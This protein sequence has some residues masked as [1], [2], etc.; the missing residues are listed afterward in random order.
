MIARCA[1]TAQSARWQQPNAWRAAW[2]AVNSFGAFLLT[3]CAIYLTLGVS[4]WLTISLA[5]LAGL[6]LV[7]VFI[8]FHDC[9]HGSFFE[10]RLANDALGVVTGF[11]A[12]VPYHHWR[13]EHAIHHGSA[14]DLERRGTGDVWT[15]TVSEYLSSPRARRWAYRIV[16]SP[17]IL[18]SVGPLALLLLWQRM[19]RAS[20]TRRERHSVWWT[21]VGLLCM[22]AGLSAVFGIVPYIL[23]QLTVLLV[24]GSVGVWLFY[25]QHQFE[26]AYWERG[27]DWDFADAALKGSSY[28]ELP[29]VLRWLTGNIGF[30]HVHHFNPKI[31]NYHLR[32]C[33]ESAPAFRNVKPMRLA[34]GVRALRLR[35]WDESSKKLVGFRHLRPGKGRQPSQRRR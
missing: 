10:S 3:W 22:V 35:L 14:G 29:S 5:T 30:H 1:E 24:G 12:F 18:L 31:P 4:W 19:P 16:R 26:D 21:N 13:G 11:F 34:A 15:M 25:L 20:A 6:L 7:R 8:I 27:E 33:H 17:V 28:L 23:I 2:Q 9:G 32:P